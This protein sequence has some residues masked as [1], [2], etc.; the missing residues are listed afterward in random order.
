MIRYSTCIINWPKKMIEATD[1]K[2]TKL[3]TMNGGFHLK[4][5]TLRPYFT[6]N[7]RGW[8]LMIDRAITID[9]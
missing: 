8:G 7:E 3:L 1:Y 6:Q 4:S 5:S 2:T 9:E